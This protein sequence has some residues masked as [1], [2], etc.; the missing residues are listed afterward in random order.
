MWDMTYLQYVNTTRG[1]TVE[2]EVNVIRLTT[3][4]YVGKECAGIPRAEKD[5]P[6]HANFI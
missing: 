5:T 2:M 3:T 4:T 6:K 1:V